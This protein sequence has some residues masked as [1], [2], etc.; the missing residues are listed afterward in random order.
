MGS[1]EPGLQ[2]TRQFVVSEDDTAEAVGSGDA[3]VLATPRVLGLAEETSIA[4][5]QDALADGQTSLG[6]YA[7]VEHDAPSAVGA[8]IEVQA[9]LVERQDRHLTFDI[10]VRQE[11]EVVARVHHRRTLVDR[12]DFLARLRG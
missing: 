3:P 12:D 8:E 1:L 10:E 9:R 6:T 7:E 4:A 2:A 11:G 5:I